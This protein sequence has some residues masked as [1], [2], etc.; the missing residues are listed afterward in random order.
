[1]NLSRQVQTVLPVTLDDAEAKAKHKE[2]S[3]KAMSKAFFKERTLRGAQ[4]CISE[5]C[6][7]KTLVSA[8]KFMHHECY[9]RE[10]AKAQGEKNDE[11][12]AVVSAGASSSDS[13][14]SAEVSA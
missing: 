6:E 8:N 14:G 4:N 13:G 3:D 12:G 7:L 2:A 5:G 9:L 1:M 10:L 11:S